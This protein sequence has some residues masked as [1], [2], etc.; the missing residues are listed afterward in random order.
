MI[1][2]LDIGNS[3]VKGAVL[4]GTRVIGSESLDTALCKSATLL[5]DMIRR[6][7]N[8]VLSLDGAW[9]SSVV[10]PVTVKAI[11]AI[12]RQ[13]GMTARLVDY[14]S[15]FPFEL[16]TDAPSRVG[17]DRLCAAA[18]ALGPRRRNAVVIDAGS[19]VTVDIVRDGVF[20]GGAI[21]VGPSLALR[22]LGRYASQLPEIDFSRVRTP[23]PSRFDDTE[24][25]M[26]LGAGAGC[27]GAIREAVRFLEESV[28]TSPAK[29]I[30]GGAAPSLLP[31]L[32]R[33]W[34]HDPDLT[35]KGIHTISTLN[36]PQ[37]DR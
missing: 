31:R 37:N 27:A 19:A 11:R 5:G 30:T 24:S 13:A 2:A 36:G 35:L 32:P 17:S 22:A 23:F 15:R 26:T 8:A 29:F 25:A 14:R 6:V 16:A 3:R 1:L 9:V 12:E 18:G 7:A 28:G 34:H 21:A 4:D 10:P 20:L 33:S